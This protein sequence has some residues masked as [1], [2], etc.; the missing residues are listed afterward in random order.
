MTQTVLQRP[1]DP[2]IYLFVMGEWFGYNPQSE[3]LGSG[4]MGI[5]YL[6]FRCKN[7][8]RIAVKR[9]K[10][11]Y[12]NVHV[13]RERARQEASLAFRHPNL[14]EM[15]GY[16]EYAPNNGPIFILSKYVHGMTLDEYVKQNLSDIP[17]RMEKICNVICSVLDALDYIHSRGVIHRDIKPSNIMVEEGSNIRLM[18]LGISR[19]NVGNSYSSYGFIGTPEYSA[20][21][22]ILRIE[23]KQ[24]QITAS[25]DFYELGITMYELLAGNNPFDGKT[26][27]ETLGKQMKSKLPENEQI[28]GRL[29]N[30]I[31]KATEKNQ[32]NRY[33]TA[34]EFKLAIKEA[35]K[36]PPS[37]LSVVMAWGEKNAVLI[38]CMI[39]VIVAL[40]LLL[41]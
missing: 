29:M 28:T 13:I 8:E 14:V 17:D 6:G 34:K 24:A 36:A 31:W 16:C 10:D 11:E 39:G 20:P 3:P 12:A 23:N 7:G 15:I 30:V 9:V 21:E 2:N 1:G 37:K 18:D 26:E 32:A 40:L 22:Q 33:Q 27:A 19:M 5:V 25:T 4:A 38:G 35:L 41:I